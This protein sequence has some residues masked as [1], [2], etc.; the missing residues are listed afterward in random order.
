MS[1]V[2]SDEDRKKVIDD[3][4]D[5]PCS[6]CC[7]YCGEKLPAKYEFKDGKIQR[8]KKSGGFW[9]YH[10]EKCEARLQVLKE[11]D[12]YNKRKEREEKDWEHEG[13]V[14]KL[15]NAGF[16]TEQANVLIGMFGG[17]NE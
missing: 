5:F 12:A 13:K 4:R 9:S 2:L 7:V 14:S 8:I 3:N 6:P 10:M 15:R 16:T 1:K 17:D 11:I